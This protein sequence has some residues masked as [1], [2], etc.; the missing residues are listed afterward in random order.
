MENPGLSKNAQ[1]RL[2][3]QKRFA[4]T[5]KEWKEKQKAKKKAKKALRNSQKVGDVGKIEP[6]LAPALTPRREPCGSLVIDL[7]YEELMTE[8]V[9]SIMDYM[10]LNSEFRN[11][12][13]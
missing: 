1:K 3:K 4:E 12:I 7:G 13:V 2:D 11:F 10:V 6:T 5:R 8:K 9:G